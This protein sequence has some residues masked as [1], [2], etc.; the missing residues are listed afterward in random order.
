MSFRSRNDM[1]SL[2]AAA[3]RR[4]CSSALATGDCAGLLEQTRN[5][6]ETIRELVGL[7]RGKRKPPFPEPDRPLGEGTLARGLVALVAYHR[8]V[9]RGIPHPWLEDAVIEVEPI[10]LGAQEVV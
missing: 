5:G 1:Y 7:V 6:Y 9:E 2:T 10:H 3:K 4:W 8:H